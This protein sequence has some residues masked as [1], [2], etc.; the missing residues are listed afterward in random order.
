MN[1]ILIAALLARASTA[2]TPVD[3]WACDN[4]IEVWCVADGCDVKDQ[5][6][7]TPMSIVADRT[8]ALSV[9]AY[10]GC[11][12]AQA[13]VADFAGR[14][15]WTAENASFSSVPGGSFAADLTLLIMES[16]GVGFVRAGGFAT[17]LLCQRRA[18]GLGGVPGE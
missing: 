14:L 18:P 9:C 7:T 8:G 3:A 11:W 16:D 5:D 4:Q 17:P 2:G 10:S 13:N 6:E 12:E 15:V 1:A